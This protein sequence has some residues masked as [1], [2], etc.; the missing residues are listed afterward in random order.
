MP[1]TRKVK[2]AKSPVPMIDQV[3]AVLEKKK[4]HAEDVMRS[5]CTSANGSRTRGSKLIGKF[6]FVC[7][8]NH[9]DR[10]VFGPSMY[11]YA[12]PKDGSERDRIM[13]AAGE[14][15]V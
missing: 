5:L 4:L 1:R 7:E 14:D 2:R 15:A 12:Y 3:R 10:G 6:R 9:I 11:L 13:V 8:R